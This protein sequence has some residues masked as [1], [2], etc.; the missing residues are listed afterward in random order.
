[1]INKGTELNVMLFNETWSLTKTYNNIKLDS[2]KA[3]LS[4]LKVGDNKGKLLTGWVNSEKVIAKISTIE[5]K[6]NGFDTKINW[7][8]G[9]PKYEVSTKNRYITCF[10]ANYG[11]ISC[12]YINGESQICD[13]YATILDKNLEK[14]FG[15][16]IYKSNGGC[17]FDKARHLKD[18][19]GVY[20]MLIGEYNMKCIIKELD[21]NN[22]SLNDKTSGGYFDV[23]SDCTADTM[24]TDM[25]VISETKFATTC[26]TRYGDYTGNAHVMV[27][28]YDENGNLNYNNFYT[29]SGSSW[30]LSIYV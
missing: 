11:R 30:R 17:A 8:G 24:T 14:K 4:V 5:P 13:E 6:G 7:N 18:E 10:E 19:L 21:N 23:Y 27:E 26:I 9:V 22:K 16:I 25:T 28:V 1:M 15:D 29:S 20:C 3:H 2:F 12:L